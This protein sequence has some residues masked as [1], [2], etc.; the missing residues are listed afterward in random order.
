M[1]VMAGLEGNPLITTEFVLV[2][3]MNALSKVG[4][5]HKPLQIIDK[6]TPL[7]TF[8]VIWSNRELFN[9]AIK[10]YRDRP[11]KDWS[12]TD[13]A[14]FVVMKERGISAAFTSDKHFEQAGFGKLL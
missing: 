5:R 4:L 7:S 2:E 11:D 13:C 12:L 14:S 6:W 8:E 1:K 10:L 3:F 9:S